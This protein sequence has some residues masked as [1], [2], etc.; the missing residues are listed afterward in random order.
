MTFEDSARLM[1]GRGT[2]CPRDA[3][4]VSLS[5]VVT[6]KSKSPLRAVMEIVR[7]KWSTSWSRGRGC[8]VSWLVYKFRV[9]SCCSG[10]NGA[11]V[12]P[13][14]L[15]MA[16][17]VE[18]LPVVCSKN[19][20]GNVAE[21]KRRGLLWELGGVPHPL[22]LPA[23][24]YVRKGQRFRGL[25]SGRVLEPSAFTPRPV[26]PERGKDWPESSS[27][28]RRSQLADSFPPAALAGQLQAL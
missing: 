27:P 20:G 23:G 17:L 1:A 13:G 3:P 18:M 22:P 5:C 9:C 7:K 10:M 11:A 4:L 6:R 24:P 25:R 8:L 19:S 16:G 21:G 12:L 2:D 15:G 26:G 28:G 14:A